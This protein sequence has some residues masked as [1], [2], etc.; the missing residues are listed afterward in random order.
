MAEGVRD[1]DDAEDSVR[2][3]TPSERTYEV[4][5]EFAGRPTVVLHGPGGFGAFFLVTGLGG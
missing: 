2:V 3:V 5:V 1:E 4:R